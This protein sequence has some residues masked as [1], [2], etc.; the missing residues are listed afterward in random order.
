MKEKISTAISIRIKNAPFTV[1]KL[2]FLSYMSKNVK[3][4]QISILHLDT[5]REIST[6]MKAIH[7]LITTPETIETI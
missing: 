3:K 2:E 7:R 4:E 1:V 6:E 5:K